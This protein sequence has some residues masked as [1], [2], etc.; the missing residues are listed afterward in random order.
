MEPEDKIGMRGAY[1]GFTLLEML[2]VIGILGILLA[3]F[4][5]GFMGAPKKAERQKC[6]ELV[7]NTATALATLFDAKGAWPK[8]LI[9]NSNKDAGLDAKAAYPLAKGGY[10]S[11]QSDADSQKCTGYDRLGVVSPWAQALIKAK[12]TNARETDKVPSGGTIADHRLRYA[13]DLDGDGIIDG[14][15][16]NVGGESVRIR[17]AAAVWCCGADGTIEAYSRGQRT[18]D[19]YS[20]AH[21]Q[22]QGM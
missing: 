21:G 17:A 14:P 22:T 1:G 19:V 8:A 13:L 12:G 20:W 9:D 15:A 7:S 5:S 3:I 4:G 2:V 6:Q 16:A 10:L 11:L 18:D